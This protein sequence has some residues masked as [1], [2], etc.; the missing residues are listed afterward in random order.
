MPSL[1]APEIQPL[2]MAQPSAKVSND[3]ST[4]SVPATPVEQNASKEPSNSRTRREQL[5]PPLRQILAP[6]AKAE[7]RRIPER[8]SSEISQESSRQRSGAAN[9]FPPTGT[10]LA[11]RAVSRATNNRPRPEETITGRSRRHHH[12]PI[13]RETLELGNPRRTVATPKVH[14]K[15]AQG[16]TTDLQRLTLSK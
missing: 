10:L 9:E 2:I 13:A 15:A 5:K 7:Q 3:G 11:S 8:H 6:P 1:Q 16:E 14:D 4:H 12:L